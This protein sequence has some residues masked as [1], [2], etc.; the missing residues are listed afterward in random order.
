MVV[1]VVVEE[2]KSCG[3][4]GAAPRLGERSA[5]LKAASEPSRDCN[6]RLRR[7]IGVEALEG[8]KSFLHYEYGAL[9]TSNNS[10]NSNNNAIAN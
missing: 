10:N 3:R 7:L 5:M 1:V 2:E 9:N 4:T 8:W 6:G